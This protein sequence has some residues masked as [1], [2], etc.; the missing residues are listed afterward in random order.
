M[1]SEDHELWEALAVGHAMRAL[2]PADDAQFRQHL[3]SCE[4]C[5]GLLADNEQLVSSLGFAAEPIEPPPALRDRILAIS[6]DSG[7]RVAPVV[8]ELGKRRAARRMSPM[9]RWA[10]AAAVVSAIASSG[11]TYASVHNGNG[12]N[13]AWGYQCLTDASCRHMP[14]VSG[15]AT[16]GAVVLE[17]GKAYILSQSLPKSGEGDQYVVWTG[18]ARGKMTALTA[19]RVTGD[20]PLNLLEKVPNLKGVA[21][22]AVSREKRGPFPELPSTPLGIAT[23]PQPTI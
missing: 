15:D 17:H 21:A 2:E 8:D 22:M 16:I 19:F 10:A 11:I 4:A 7:A 18:D 14:L 12:T 9:V 3:A 6:R 5:P 13:E 20:A 1:I 23:V